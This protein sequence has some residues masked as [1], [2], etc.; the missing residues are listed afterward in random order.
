[1][2]ESDS[3]DLLI[4]GGGIN[5]A[6]IARDAAGRGLKVLLCEQG[7]LAGA[8]SSAS[9]KLVHG[10][11]RYL[12]MYE[13][14]LV[15]EALAEREVLLKA[16]PHI[17][18]PMR[19]VLPH[20]R[21]LR[22]AWMI[23]MGLFLY[24]HIGGRRTL[25][26]TAA[27]DLRHGL[28]GA[29][30]KP[31]LVKGFEYSDCWVDDSRLVVLNAMDAVNHGA[32]V[33]VGTRCANARR[34]GAGTGSRWQATLV[35]QATGAERQVKA[36]ILVNSA[37]PW[38]DQFLQT[39]LGNNA[40]QNLK[41]VKG[42]HIIVP[43]LYEGEHAYILQ[44]T[45]KRVVFAIPYEGRFTLIGTTDLVYEGDPGGPAITEAETAYLCEAVN[46]YFERPVAPSDVVHTYSGVRPLYDDAEAN[47]SEVTRDYV[48]D[49]T[50]DHGNTPLL[51][52]YGGK[53]TTYRRLAEHAIAKLEPFLPG[54]GPAWTEDAALPG[55]DLDDGFDAFVPELQSRYPF[56]P[57]PLAYRYARLYGSLSYEFLA[58]AGTLADLGEEFG[59]GLYARE[60]EY[61]I[62]R[63]WA[64]SAADILWRRTKL[65]LVMPPEGRDRLADWVDR[66]VGTGEAA[67]AS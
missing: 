63:E 49:V 4:V 43:R 36:R 35:D 9:S 12:E 14:R 23:R 56:L 27:L 54:L 22:P 32:E 31:E 67:L 2:S 10:G 53:I 18:W 5:G 65:G 45:D 57:D 46:R 16:A 28:Q 17:I 26:G 15:R 21:L 58:N 50:S 24:D 48:F 13:F 25:P 33:L 59:A 40:A 19:F 44:N 47:P 20:N 66:R 30:L 39:G 51:S 29:P 3:V 11:L 7:D 64:R 62:D 34:V 1:M 37:G 60:A 52:I 41:L 38:V 8:T 6:G 61:L 55:G 42:S